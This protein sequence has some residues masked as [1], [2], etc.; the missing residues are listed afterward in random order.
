MIETDKENSVLFLFNMLLKSEN[1]YLNQIKSGQYN[2]FS[3]NCL[4]SLRYYI[5]GEF[6]TA[7]NYLKDVEVLLN[8]NTDVEDL[9]LYNML[10]GYINFCEKN[11]HVYLL[12]YKKAIEL[13]KNNNKE[14]FLSELEEVF[15]TL[16]NG[17]LFISSKNNDPLSA[18]VKIGQAVAA[19]K[20]INKLLFTIAEEA[21]DAVQADR[22]TVFLYD[23]STDELWSKVALG[24]GSHELRFNA[25]Q[26]L[27]GHVF[28]TGETINIK[29]AYSDERFNKEIDLKTGY[30]TK[31]ILCMPIR[32]IEQKIIGVFQ[33]LNKLSG[34]FTKDDE[35]ILVAIGSSA[36][37]SLENAKLFARQQELLEEQKIVFDSFISTL[38]ASIDARDKITAGH[39]T[40][41]RMYATL[42][43]EQYGMQGKDMEIIQ[44]AAA[45]HDI[46]KIGIR[47]S[48]LQK[49]GKL[50][51]EEYK[52]IQEHVEITH[53]I[54][55]KIHMS[56]D[57]KLI[58]EIACSHHEKYNGTG[59][60]RQLKGEE[61]HLGGRIL[62]VADVFDAITSKRHY[63]D[64]MPIKKVISILLGDS[65]THFDGNVVD[66]FLSIPLNKVVQ[67]FMTENNCEFIQSD[68]EFLSK[69]DLRKLYDNFENPEYSELIT[70]FNRYYIGVDVN[71]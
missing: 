48:V 22:C 69:Y 62:A 51:P 60:Y 70:I 26:G 52:H 6:Q 40:R 55:E 42:I 58:T 28:R 46:G 21:R 3:I 18:L 39:S 24:L 29:D 54:L 35:D 12:H 16:K 41:V 17:N 27:A 65:G 43:A 34:Y 8:S 19:E 25:S 59:Y 31:T 56:D 7:L 38:A 50:T 2:I 14:E 5:S 10:V 66:K 53:N 32:N 68:Y 20:D 64:K 23:S 49:E 11:G 15:R 57:F 9:I 61:I 67:V 33:I 71:E 45:L 44:K 13:S 30:V 63:R 1:E 37:I 4:N 47:D 36:G